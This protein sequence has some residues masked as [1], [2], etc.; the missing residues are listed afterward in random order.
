MEGMLNYFLPEDGDS[1]DHMNVMP[2][3]RTDQL[4]LQ[5]I[6]KVWCPYAR[7]RRPM[8]RP[9]CALG[10]LSELSCVFVCQNFPLPGEFHFRFKTAFEGTYG[11]FHFGLP[12]DAVVLVVCVFHTHF[13]HMFF[14]VL[15][16]L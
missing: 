3:P 10:V 4:K 7:A 13:C 15:V 12:F 11:E 5:H 14:F 16:F 1:S 2:L 8:E 9:R 6:K